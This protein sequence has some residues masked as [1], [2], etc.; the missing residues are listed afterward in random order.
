MSPPRL[1]LKFPLPSLPN[2]TELI[3][4][5]NCS[6]IEREGGF[7]WVTIDRVTRYIAE[8]RVDEYIRE[9]PE[10]LEHKCKV[11]SELFES[12]HSLRIHRGM[13]HKE[14]RP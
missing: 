5:K 2:V 10:P 13:K 11:C 12:A 4:G 6:R 9:E 3:E 14:T 1:T 8:W 7:F